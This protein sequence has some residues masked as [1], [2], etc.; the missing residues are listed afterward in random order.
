MKIKKNN[1]TV[2]SI[3]SITINATSMVEPR[4]F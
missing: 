3:V 2:R 4:E 1:H